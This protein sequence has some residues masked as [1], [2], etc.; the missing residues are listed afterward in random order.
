MSTKFGLQIDSGLY[1][2]VMSLD[3]KLE[4]VLHRR[5]CRWWSDV[6]EIWSAGGL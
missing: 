3:T 5:G 1:K 6:D 2:S 4:A